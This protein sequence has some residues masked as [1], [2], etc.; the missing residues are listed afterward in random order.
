M[1][2]KGNSTD[3][4]LQKIKKLKKEIK[5]KGKRSKKRNSSS[6]TSHSSSSSS[7]SR[8]SHRSRSRSSIRDSRSRGRSRN[9]SEKKKNPSNERSRRGSSEDSYTPRKNPRGMSRGHDSP[10]EEHSHSGMHNPRD[11]IRRY[12]AQPEN[13]EEYSYRDSENSPHSPL[14]D[15][16]D[17]ERNN[18]QSTGKKDGA[19]SQEK[20]DSQQSVKK[21]TDMD[22]ADLVQLGGDPFANVKLSGPINKTLAT[23]W[24]KIMQIGLS[25]EIRKELI[26]KH[27]PAENCNMMAA[28]TLNAEIKN[29]IGQT[30]VKKDQFQIASQ[31]QLGAAISS[32]GTAVSKL[33]NFQLSDNKSDSKNHSISEILTLLSDSG[34]LLTD[35]H[36]E[37]SLTR[38][39]FI[40]SGR[41]SK[42][43]IVAENS[44]V[45]NSLFGENFPEQ[46]KAA[47]EVEKVGKELTKI[48]KTDKR[49]PY[50][51]P[52][53]QPSRSRQTAPRTGDLNWKGPPKKSYSN[54]RRGGPHPSRTTR[55]PQPRN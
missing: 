51:Q 19:P 12:V 46:F 11:W 48:T 26:E 14:H 44:P 52:Y 39:N 42:L 17:P 33:L 7:N 3:K 37:I 9:R 23:V 31:N 36:H 54:H 2:R 13:E 15:P 32:L 29:I 20:N 25:K 50:H 49:K 4:L 55:N 53:H 10:L 35:L 40:S 5:K 43:K 22:E 38:R 30:G 21:V 41:D 28:P 8:T 24:Q 18:L 47:R 45:D 16:E 27:P 1:G 34:K 6:E